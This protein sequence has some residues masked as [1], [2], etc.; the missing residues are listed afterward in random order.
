MDGIEPPSQINDELVGKLKIRKSKNLSSKEYVDGIISGNRTLLSQ[1]ITLIESS[2]P[3]HQQKA[4]EIIS[5][6]MKSQQSAVDSRQSVNSLQHPATSIR[7]GIT[8]A[9]IGG[10]ALAA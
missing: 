10:A 6:C 8:G 3:S 7:I 1:A 2:L 9:G 5:E 4:R